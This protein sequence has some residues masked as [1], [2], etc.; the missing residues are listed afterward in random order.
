M[1]HFLYGWN[2]DGGW[3]TFVI[4]VV[5]SN[6]QN[7][8]RHDLFLFSCTA[9]KKKPMEKNK[10]TTTKKIW[11]YTIK[12][13]GANGK[14]NVYKFVVVISLN[15]AYVL[16]YCFYSSFTHLHRINVL[17]QKWLH[18]GLV[19]RFFF[20][21]Y[22]CYSQS[23]VVLKCTRDVFSC[24]MWFFFVLFPCFVSSIFYGWCFIVV[25]YVYSFFFSFLHP[26]FV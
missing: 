22:C 18:S 14:N 6:T 20:Y 7:K 21:L 17:V 3:T 16:C 2:D 13:Q 11:M 5:Q 10:I 15:K 26:K 9:T 12:T 24:M 23:P 19:G 1:M 4:V 8:V 25:V